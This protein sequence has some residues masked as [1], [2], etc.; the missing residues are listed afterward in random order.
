MRRQ[1]FTGELS[2][3]RFCALVGST[4]AGMSCRLGT[5][6]S[7]G[8]AADN[9]RLLARYHPPL[10]T[11]TPGLYQF[12][13]GAVTSFMLVPE[14]YRPSTRVPLVVA[15]HGA[16]INADGPRAFLGPY[17]ESDGFVLMI[18]ESSDFTWDAIHG[19]YGPDLATLDAALGVAFRYCA[20]DNAR[21]CLEGFSDGAS[22][23]LGVGITNPEIFTRVVAFSPG[24][25]TPA[26]PQTEKPKIFVSH[27][28]QD[29]VLPIDLASR[30]IVPELEA[31]GYEVDYREYDGVHSVPPAIARAAV[32]FWMR[33]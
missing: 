11:I 26:R 22:Y 14:S 10:A 8:Y 6:V 15:L 25:V 21:I 24:L 27:G 5:T 4:V 12:E 29:P 20:I 7:S 33:T 28:L 16:G 13:T 32:D 18:P 1:R 17:A 3:R 31:E 9:P 30:R 19:V 23:A 2:R